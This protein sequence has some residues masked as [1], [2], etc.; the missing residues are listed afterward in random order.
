MERHDLDAIRAD[1]QAVYERQAAVFDQHRNRS[2][3]ESAWLA[4]FAERLPETGSVLD[5]GCGAGEPV[6]SELIARGFS[7]TGVDYANAMLEL[8]RSRFPDHEWLEADIRTLVIDR[9]FDGVISW[10]GFFHLS[11]DEQRRVLP[12]F[13]DYVT[14]GGPLLLTVGPGAGEVTGQV[15]NE[16]V[17]HASLDPAEYQQLLQE[18]GFGEL[19]FVARDENSGGRSIVLAIRQ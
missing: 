5:L 17:Y 12:R 9:Q 19:T 3:L 16:S 6:A 11:P 15:G 1:T 13:A 7:L 18:A 14:A 8:A 10:D 4:T 2:G